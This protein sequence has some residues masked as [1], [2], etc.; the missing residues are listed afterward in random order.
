MKEFEKHVIN[1]KQSNIED[2]KVS[3]CGKP[4]SE[5]E[6]YFQGA[7]HVLGS[8]QSASRLLPC[9]ECKAEILNLLNK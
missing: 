4:L 8:I 3:Y 7:D 5:T 9:P 6:W 1:Q 2:R